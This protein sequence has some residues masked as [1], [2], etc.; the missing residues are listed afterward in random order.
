MS[1]AQALQVRS[2]QFCMT[3]ASLLF[4]SHVIFCSVLHHTFTVTRHASHASH[5]ARHRY[6]PS[7]PLQSLRPLIHDRVSAT[8]KST[9]VSFCDPHSF[10][11]TDSNVAELQQQ[12]LATTTDLLSEKAQHE[13]LQRLHR[14]QSKQQQLKIDGLEQENE[15][16]QQQRRLCSE[17]A[18]KRIQELQS[19]VK[20]KEANAVQLQVRGIQ[21]PP[22]VVSVLVSLAVSSSG[23]IE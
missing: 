23:I 9:L 15:A 8:L 21:P 20:E 17:E 10:E 7:E 11:R 14:Q 22:S 13:A 4:L 6:R 1:Q 5:I 2:S 12:L 3:S 18:E 19:Q 16:L